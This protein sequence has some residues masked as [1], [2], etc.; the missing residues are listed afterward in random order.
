MTPNLIKR[1]VRFVECEE[2]LWFVQLPPE[3]ETRFKEMKG[4]LD[5]SFVSDPDGGWLVAFSPPELAKPAGRLE[6]L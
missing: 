3:V 1:R 6:D 5:L 2:K 4:V